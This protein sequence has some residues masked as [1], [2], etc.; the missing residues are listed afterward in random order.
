VGCGQ[1][2]VSQRCNT[3]WV[4]I[5][6]AVQPGNGCDTIRLAVDQDSTVDQVTCTA[7]QVRDGQTIALGR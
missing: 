7:S 5:V 2:T 3:C 6:P 1:H 4:L